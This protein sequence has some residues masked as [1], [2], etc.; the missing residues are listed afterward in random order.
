MQCGAS[1]VTAM[2]PATITSAFQRTVSRCVTRHSRTCTAASAARQNAP[3]ASRICSH[4]AGRPVWAARRLH[5]RRCLIRRAPAVQFRRPPI[6]R[7]LRNPSSPVFA[8][9]LLT[10]HAVQ[11]PQS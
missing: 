2:K 10:S 3:A 9:G 5:S 7:T 8:R 4:P 11:V 1:G 6:Y